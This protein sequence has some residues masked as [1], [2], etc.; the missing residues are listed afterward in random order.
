MTNIKFDLEDYHDIEIKNMYRETVIKGGE[1]HDEVMK[2]I[3]HYLTS[4]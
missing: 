3:Y 4:F 2:S 1:N